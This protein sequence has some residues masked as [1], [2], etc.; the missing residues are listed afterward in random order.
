VGVDRL[1]DAQD[2]GVGVADV[3]LVDPDREPHPGAP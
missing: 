1:A 2:V 3:H